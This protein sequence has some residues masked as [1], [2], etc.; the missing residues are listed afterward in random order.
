MGRKVH[1]SD[2]ES[3]RTSM[4]DEAASV[5]RNGI[6]ELSLPPGRPISSAWL[7]E[8][9][10]L[11][12]TPIREAINRLSAE[13]LVHV[14]PNQSVLVRP[15]DIDEINQLI[16][17]LRVAERVA[18]FYCDFADEGLLDDVARMQG[19]QR[20]AV[21]ER[22][23][24]EASHWNAAFRSRI[25]ATCRNDHLIA[26]H[27]RAIN[28]A[29]RLSCLVYAMEAKDAAHYR[30]QLKLLEDIHRGLRVAIAAK[31]RDKLMAVLAEHVAILG[32]RVAWALESAALPEM[33]LAS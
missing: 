21:R 4:V 26:F 17:A 30:Q 14:E 12:R 31:N 5:I 16:E 19:E 20:K 33:P 3:R 2:G 22:R 27:R 13:G 7:M 28:H 15:L 29:R 32:T 24:L 10:K 6:L 8:H 1:P 11:G 25:A 9:L 18:G 23:Y